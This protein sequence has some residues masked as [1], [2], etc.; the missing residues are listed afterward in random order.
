MERNKKQRKEGRKEQLFGDECSPLC[1]LFCMAGWHR[2]MTFWLYLVKQVL[3]AKALLN[4][5]HRESE[6][7]W[8]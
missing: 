5:L 2:S 6:S 8:A 7:H 3:R 1:T 4:R